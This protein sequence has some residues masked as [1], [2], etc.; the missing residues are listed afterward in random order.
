M[1][2]DK[3][4]IPNS[5]GLEFSED[6]LAPY[7]DPT[8][9]LPGWPGHRHHPD[10]SGYDPV[11]TYAEYGHLQGVFYRH[12]FTGKLRTNNPLYLFLMG[13]AALYTLFPLVFIIGNCG[14]T[15]YGCLF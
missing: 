5:E 11:D 14:S 6:Q 9:I 10:R 12:L 13:A 1:N 2:P 3:S 8:A 7:L 15:N 4:V